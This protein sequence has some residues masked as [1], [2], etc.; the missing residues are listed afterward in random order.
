[1][2]ISGL[3]NRA[4][5]NQDA[6]RDEPTHDHFSIPSKNENQLYPSRLDFFAQAQGP[7][8]GKPFRQVPTLKLMGSS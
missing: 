4:R 5:Y 7:A 8:L 2:L 6:H 1:M 3:N